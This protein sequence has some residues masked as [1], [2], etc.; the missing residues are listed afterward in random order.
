MQDS[1]GIAPPFLTWAL[2]GREWSEFTSSPR[3]PFHRRLRGLQRQPGLYG[4]VKD[5]VYLPRIEQ[6]LLCGPARKPKIWH[7]Q[8]KMYTLT[9]VRA[10]LRN[11]NF[12]GHEDRAIAEVISRR[13]SIA[14]ARVLSQV[15]SCGICGGEKWYWGRFP[16]QFSLHQMF[17]T[18]L[19]SGT[20][21]IDKLVVDIL[22]WMHR[23]H[24][25]NTLS[26]SQT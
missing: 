7:E 10:L 2:D 24:R 11:V 22:N 26:C 16:C 1:G 8:R 15:R 21:T 19:P 25:L 4:A 12:I 13:L 6:R 5:L 14:A 17:H 3:Y 20:G 9:N 23:V 18:Y